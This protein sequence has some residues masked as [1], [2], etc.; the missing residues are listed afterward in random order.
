MHFSLHFIFTALLL[1]AVLVVTLRQAIRDERRM[2]SE[3]S[4]RKNTPPGPG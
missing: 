3:S 4:Q 1:A 2:R